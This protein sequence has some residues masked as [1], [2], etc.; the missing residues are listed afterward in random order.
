MK[1]DKLRTLG[2]KATGPRLKVLQLLGEPGVGHMGA[3]EICRRL[4]ER[5]G[6]V[7]LATIYRVLAQFEAAGLVKRHSF[8]GESAIYE[9]DE[10]EHHDHMVCSSCG[11]VLELSLIHI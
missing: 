11:M 9:L 7:S 5:G 1:N 3:E 10:G 2:L 8:D 4:H 6:N